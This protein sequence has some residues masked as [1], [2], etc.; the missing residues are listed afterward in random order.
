MPFAAKRVAHVLLEVVERDVGA[1]AARQT[2]PAL[3]GVL[4]EPAQQL[5]APGLGAAGIHVEMAER[6]DHG[7][8]RPGAGDGDVQAPL[9]ALEEQRAEPV[10]QRPA[11]VLAVADAQ[12]DRV[13]LVALHPLEVLDEE[14]LVP[15]RVE[16]VLELG[17][18]LDGALDRGFDPPRMG[19]AHRDDAERL[20]AAWSRACSSTSSTTR[21][22]SELLLSSELASLTCGTSTC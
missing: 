3:R 16:E 7:H 20:A 15:L 5:D 4:E 14:P 22:T 11:R 2:G 8:P 21:F 9:P 17:M 6:R 19:D 13:A 12:D 18:L 1:L 10:R